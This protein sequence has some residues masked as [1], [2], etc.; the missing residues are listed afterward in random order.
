MPAYVKGAEEDLRWWG[1][2]WDGTAVYQSDRL[3]SY[4]MALARLAETGSLYASNHSRAQV[5][6]AS[7][8]VS[9]VDGEQIFPE[10]LRGNPVSADDLEEMLPASKQAASQP[11]SEFTIRFRVPDGRKLSF[12]DNRSG[13]HCYQSGTDFGDFI[14]WSRDGIPA[15]ELA[16]VVDDAEMGITEVVRGE[17]LLVSTARQLLLYEALG[18]VAPE[19]YHCQLVHDPNTGKRMS[20]THKSLSIRQLRSQGF[21]PAKPP[22]FYFESLSLPG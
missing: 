9:P 2:D 3:A 11:G 6:A 19:W 20:K 5:R 17:D 10:Q 14:V 15:Y 4:R 22:H 8:E 12:I 16:V 21:P 1:L 18:W 13:I 7:R